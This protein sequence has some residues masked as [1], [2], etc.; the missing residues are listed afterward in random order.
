M[1]RKEQKERII[2][3]ARACF[4]RYGYEKTTME[5]IGR[6]VGLNKTSLYHYFKNKDDIFNQVILLEKTD[7]FDAIRSKLKRIKECEKRIFTFLEERLYFFS[8]VPTLASISIDTIQKNQPL[9][10]KL[11]KFLS[12]VEI[13]FLSEII[14]ECIENGDII[15]CD[16]NRVA[17]SIITV[18]DAIKMKMVKNLNILRITDIDFSGINKEIIF[19]VSLILQG[20]KR[21]G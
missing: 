15:Q 6:Q 21:E 5:D 11:G 8:K 1:K 12:K 13:E 14:G 19:T 9:F 17:Q 16:S 10:E 20:L 18:A 7:Y 3:A 2:T 4:A